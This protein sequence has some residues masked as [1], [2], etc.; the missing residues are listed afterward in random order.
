[1]RRADRIA[2]CHKRRYPMKTT[3]SWILAGMILCV[4]MQVVLG[5]SSEPYPISE[6]DRPMALPKMTLEPK[7]ELDLDFF[8]VE[9]ADNWVSIRAGT[10][11]GVTDRVEAGMSLP[12][13]FAPEA[14]AGDLQMYGLYELDRYVEGKLHSAGRLTMSIPLSDAHPHGFGAAFIMLA[15]APVKFKLH[16][17]F[18]AI[19]GLGMG[20]FAG[21]DNFPNYFLLHFDFGGL[22]Q[23][24]EQLAISLQ[25][26]IHGMIGDNSQT[27]VPFFLRGQYTLMGDL[28]IYADF[29]FVDLNNLGGDWVQLIFGA[30]FRTGV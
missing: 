27:M 24:T 1:M 17:K 5:Q 8:T 15:D 23:P 14:K 16:E 13:S 20:F 11:L 2:G 18:A 7:G 29:G 30:A 9:G 22:V 21:R 19:G 26:G 25:M 28:D 3:H 12:L 6:I 4:P 10:G